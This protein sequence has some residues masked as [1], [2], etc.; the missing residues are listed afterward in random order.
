VLLVVRVHE[1][2]L[3]RQKLPSELIGYLTRQGT[4]VLKFFLHVSRKEQKKR[5]M[6]RLD[7]QE[8]HW[9]F[10]IADLH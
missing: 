5:P 7:N 9:K 3:K 10:S 1:E 8:K 2:I 6:A 4:A